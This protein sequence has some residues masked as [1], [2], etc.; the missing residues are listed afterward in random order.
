MCD[1][2]GVGTYTQDS[3]GAAL[4]LF[5]YGTSEDGNRRM[6]RWLFAFGVTE[7]ALA[8]STLLPKCATLACSFSSQLSVA[9]QTG[10]M[11]TLSLHS[12][13]HPVSCIPCRGL[14]FGASL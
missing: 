9:G 7:A 8:Y 12:Q 11:G 14:G 5:G 1:G 13:D 4:L 10:V 6:L 3:G 2:V